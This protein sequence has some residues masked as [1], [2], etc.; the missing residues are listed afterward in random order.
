MA[1]RRIDQADG[2]RR[3]FATD[4]LRVVALLPALPGAGASA[5]ALDLGAALAAAGREV[6]LVGTGL[7]ARSGAFAPAAASGPVAGLRRLAAQAFAADWPA[8]VA[9]ND[10][11]V[12]DG[13]GPA[14]AQG[15]LLPADRLDMVVVVN[16]D[17]DSI[18]AAYAIAKRV[19]AQWPRQRLHVLVNRARSDREARA[20]H[21]N[22]T[23]VAQRHLG[24]AVGYAGSVPEDPALALAHRTGR[25]LA[26]AMPEAPAATALRGLAAMLA[27]WPVPRSP[28]PGSAAGTLQDAACARPAPAHEHAHSGI[29]RGLP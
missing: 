27:A 2:L 22:M 18:T 3:L 20:I 12:I 15:R 8:F 13:D 17:P 6:L 7:P 19:A 16:R 14:L 24:V 28:L 21:A 10:F 25:T 11:V 9:G 5:I 23:R 26:E 29:L 4:R 1:E